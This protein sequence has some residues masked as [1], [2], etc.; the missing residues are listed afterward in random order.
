[1]PDSSVTASDAPSAP[2]VAATGD[3]AGAESGDGPVATQVD[4]AGPH[5]G[6]PDA[7]FDAPVDAA[8]VDAPVD[9]GP[10]PCT[11]KSC[12]TR[13]ACV[14]GQ[15]VLARRVFVSS[16]TYTGNLGGHAGADA[17]CQ[18]LASAAGLGGT[19]MAWISDSASWPSARFNQASYPY[20]LLDG[21]VFAASW[22][23]LVGGSLQHGIALDESSHPPTGTT[24][25]W[26]ATNTDGTLNADG[27]SSFTSGSH[28]A[29]TPAVGVAG[30]TDVT[31]TD[32]YLQFCDRS[33]HIYCFEQ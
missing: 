16:S 31:W 8:F 23:A 5:E 12:G 1:V 20:R 6:G 26:T 14:A 11:L 9:T 4:D 10:P 27:C 15:C 18:Q 13:A 30:N 32:V 25:T 29:S 33:D 7:S 28:T 21:T 17:T 24:E 2:D 3:S 19:W 22:S